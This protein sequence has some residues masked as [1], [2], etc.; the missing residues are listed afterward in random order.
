MIEKETSFFEE[1][2][3]ICGQEVV[4]KVK[5]TGWDPIKEKETKF[6]LN[7]DQLIRI[8]DAGVY[9]GVDGLKDKILRVLKIWK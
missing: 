9:N 5:A 7:V 4:D 1:I 8:Y 6:E 3:H 2:E